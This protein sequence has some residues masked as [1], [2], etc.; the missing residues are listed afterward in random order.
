MST[1]SQDVRFSG[2]LHSNRRQW[3]RGC[4][5]VAPVTDCKV[6]DRVTDRKVSDSVVDKP[7]VIY[8]MKKINRYAK[9]PPS[10]NSKGFKYRRNCVAH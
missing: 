9:G 4:G 6:T 1:T 3:R 10:P 5:V 7:M 2:E 8:P